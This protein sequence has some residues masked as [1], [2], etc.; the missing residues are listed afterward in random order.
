MLN[1]QGSE[2]SFIQPSPFNIETVPVPILAAIAAIAVLFLLLISLIVAVR[3]GSRRIDELRAAQE[4][5][6]APLLLQQEIDSLREHV[7][8]SLQASTQGV[9]RQIAQLAG[10]LD[11]RLHQSHSL[12]QQT[13]Q[14]L[15]ER[16]DTTTRVVGNVQRSLGVLEEGH[17]Q[18][19]AI[20]KDIASLQDLLRPPKLRGGLG[21][22]LLEDLLAQVLPPAHV[23]LQYG[24]ADGRKVDAVLKLDG[25]LVPV[26]AKFPLDNFQRLR[27]APA[28]EQAR[29][30]RAFITD[31][32]RHIDAVA[33]YILPDEGTLDFALMYVPAENIFYEIIVRDERGSEESL[34][35]YALRQRVVPVS[36]AS[37]YAYLQAIALGLRG[38]HVE[39]RAREIMAQLGRLQGDVA[40]LRDSF[41]VVGRHLGNASSSLST[42]DAA[43]Q[44]L[45]TR[46]AGFAGEVAPGAEPEV[47]P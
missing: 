43:L 27:Q 7:G 6:R 5:D 19:L 35:E 26:D 30:R 25:G 14:T 22:L 42:A 13:Q 9:Q 2:G 33:K 16:L 18:L 10:Q 44:R 46:L 45:E 4:A 3:R 28:P 12:A 32:R 1:A 24:F 11:Q 8:R 15:G 40:R 21:E 23:A 41:R 20:G 38:L 39:E 34:S 36:P 17:R 31:V 37:F 29:A 47:G